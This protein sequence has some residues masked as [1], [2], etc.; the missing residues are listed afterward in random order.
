VRRGADDNHTVSTS[1]TTEF[2]FSHEELAEEQQRVA[3][4]VRSAF[5]T[6]LGL[7]GGLGVSIDLFVLSVHG[8]DSPHRFLVDLRLGMQPSDGLA[9]TGTLLGVAIAINVALAAQ[10]EPTESRHR[11]RIADWQLR[12]VLIMLLCGIAAAATALLTWTSNLELAGLGGALETLAL[13]LTTAGVAAAVQPSARPLEALFADAYLLKKQLAKLEES[14]RR[15]S[16]RHAWREWNQLLTGFA[17]VALGVAIGLLIGVAGL[18]AFTAVGVPATILNLLFLGSMAALFGTAV[19]FGAAKQWAER[20]VSLDRRH[21]RRWLLIC[22]LI[23]CVAASLFATAGPFALRLVL[24]GYVLAMIGLPTAM[25]VLENRWPGR[26][27]L[28]PLRAVSTRAIARKR[29]E[30]EK[31]LTDIRLRQERLARK[32]D[33]TIGGLIKQ[34]GT[35]ALRQLIRRRG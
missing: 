35:A 7:G 32:S 16:V 1:T 31:E 10:Q 5:L 30:I 25:C 2:G 8:L 23:V 33:P 6:I 12:M 14:Q 24:A 26:R 22:V 3:H 11:I 20:A 13:A 4:R 18:A 21:W 19:F 9:A 15:L 34:L 27:L 28:A 29:S 17:F